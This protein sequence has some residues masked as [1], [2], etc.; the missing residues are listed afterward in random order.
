MG[1]MGTSR[2]E[3]ERCPAIG[4]VGHRSDREPMIKK[5]VLHFPDG[6]VRV[7]DSATHR[8]RVTDTKV[9]VKSES[10]D[11]EEFAGTPIA[12]PHRQAF[13]RSPRVVAVAAA[14]RRSALFG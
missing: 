9:I 7:F 2:V 10:G 13:D 4:P 3:G 5:L 14:R 1:V 11:E 8:I 6:S 12:V